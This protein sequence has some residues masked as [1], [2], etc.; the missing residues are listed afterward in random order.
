[1]INRKS[2]RCAILEI[3]PQ[4][5]KQIVGLNKKEKWGDPRKY[6]VDVERQP[7]GSQPLYIISPDP[8]EKLTEDEVAMV[9][10]FLARI[11]LE[12]M[13]AVPSVDEVREKIGM[14]A[15]NT[16]SEVSNDFEETAVESTDSDSD[17]DDFDF[18]E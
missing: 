13:T 3:G 2:D 10:E 9:K 11:D 14:A 5:L 12:K 4:I 17:D 7:K 8:K 18:G 6:D 16:K 15:E 1:M